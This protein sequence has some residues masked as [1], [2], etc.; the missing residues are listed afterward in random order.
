MYQSKSRIAWGVIGCGWVARDYGIPAILNGA[1]SKLAAVCDLNFDNLAA[2]VPEDKTIVRAT[3]LD[4][5]LSAPDLEAVYIAT[6]NNSHRFLTERCA[7]VGKHVL[8]EKPMAT[9]YADAAA[10]VEVCEKFGVQYATAFDQRFQA[11]HLR[12]KE[13][14]DAGELGEIT[15]ARVHYACWLPRDWTVDNWRVNQEIAGGGA[16]IDLA[17]HSVD[18]LQFLLGAEIVDFNVF[19]QSKIQDYAVDDGGVA[20]AKFDGGALA[21][22]NVAYNCPDNFPRRTLEIVGTKAMAIARNTMGQTAGGSL[23]LIDANNGE[24]REIVIDVNADISPFQRQIEVF[25]DC[26]LH[27]KPFPFA[28]ARDLATMR[29]LSETRTK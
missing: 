22:I 21:T 24:S 19:L 3:D 11:R 29:I 13:L 20:I 4:E 28:P 25:S 12:L 16:F 15:A 14:I 23:I 18:L 8:C 26:L 1:N 6:P 17:P 7:E 27:E 9:N 2:V 10:M 5:F